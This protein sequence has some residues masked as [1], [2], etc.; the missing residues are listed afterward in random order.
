M[1][2]RGERANTTQILPIYLTQIILNKKFSALLSHGGIL[3]HTGGFKAS[4]LE[5]EYYH[6][7]KYFIIAI[8]ASTPSF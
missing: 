7:T 3:G 6:Y 5:L 1:D 2:R 8:I 4:A